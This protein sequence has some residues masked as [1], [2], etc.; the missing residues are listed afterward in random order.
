[1]V[2]EWARSN[3]ERNSETKKLYEQRNREV[4][5]AKAKAREDA[6]KD[7]YHGYGAKYRA[8]HADKE[9]ERNRLKRQKYRAK[10]LETAKRWREANPWSHQ[11]RDARRR[12]AELNATPAWANE[13]FIE[14][15]YRLAKLR[16]QV[17]GGKWHVDHIV[18]L[19]GRTVCGLH[20]EHN[21]QVITAV[22][23][24]QKCNVWWPDMP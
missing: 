3:K 2:A 24:R 15:A 7:R 5:R 6:S 17:C 4:I 12:A 20:V 16:E 11:A 21:L 19:Q 14:E 10:I 13:F 8:L 18:P 1:M 23:N 22:A 9:R